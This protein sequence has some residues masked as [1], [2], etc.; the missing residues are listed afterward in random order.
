MLAVEP[1]DSVWLSAS[2]GTGKTQVLVG[3]VLRLLLT[4]GCGQRTSVSTFTKA[5]RPRW[6]SG[7]MR[8]SRAGADE[9]LAT[10][11]GTCLPLVR[12]R[13]AT[14]LAPGC[15]RQRTRQPGGGLRID[16]IHAFRAGGFSR[17]SPRRRGL[18]PGTKPMADRDRELLAHRVLADLLV[19]WE[20]R[21]SGAD[22]ALEMLSCAWAPTRRA[23]G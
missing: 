20:E 17:S 10:G 22:R 16:T 13:L 1:D 14:Q 3:A 23:P 21:A 19:E 9:A 5:A 15:C 2:A 7:S 11:A 4:P 18:I 8:C 12:G 6:P